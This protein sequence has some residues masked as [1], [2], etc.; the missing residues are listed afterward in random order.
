MLKVPA[1]T[2][3]A[4]RAGP[5]SGAQVSTFVGHDRKFTDRSVKVID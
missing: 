4:V 3:V 5:V 1:Q 2:C